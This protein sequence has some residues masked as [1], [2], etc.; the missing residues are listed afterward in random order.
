[1][2]LFTLPFLL[3]QLPGANPANLPIIPG[4]PDSLVFHALPAGHGFTFRTAKRD[5]I[6]AKPSGNST[7]MLFIDP[8][9][10]TLHR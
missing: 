3:F 6:T 7:R 2:H 5:V 1:M 10:V 8:R 9:A 4:P